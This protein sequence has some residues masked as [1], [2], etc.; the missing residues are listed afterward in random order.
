M[1]D[2]TADY[3][4]KLEAVYVGFEYDFSKIETIEYSKKLPVICKKH[5][6]FYQRK[7]HLLN[8]YGCKKCSNERK[9]RETL[10][11]VENFVK[12]AIKAHG[13]KYDYSKAVYKGANKKLQIICPV[14]GF[15]WQT[16]S[17]HTNR[18]SG[19][20][21]CGKM[22]AIESKLAPYRR[23]FIKH[24]DLYDYSKVE[25]VG[26]HTK[27]E[28]VCPVHG[29]FWQTPDAHKRGQGC[30]RCSSIVSKNEEELG[31]FIKSI[32]YNDKNVITN[33]RNI[34]GPME[35]DI[36]IPHK[37]I[38]IEFDGLYWHSTARIKERN[39]HLRKTEACE[40]VGYR[41]IHIY[42]DEWEYKKERV[43]SFLS[44]VLHANNMKNE[45]ARLL[46][47][48]DVS[49]VE[50]RMFLDEHHIQGYSGSSI[51]IGLVNKDGVLISY[52]GFKNKKNG[53]FELNRFA[54]RGNVR[55]GFSKLLAHFK[56]TYDWETIVSYADRRHSQGG[57]Y[58]KNGFDE[59]HETKPSF[60]YTR[61]TVR[62][63]RQQ[64]MKKYLPSKFSDTYDPSLTEWENMELQGYYQIWNCGYTKYETHNYNPK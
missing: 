6:L 52:M 7:D 17:S 35:L 16:P 3:I 57:V 21:E 39:Y 46:Y 1:D 13:Y 19:C 2:K 9:S 41:L 43:K 33:D 23:S 27:I 56:R 24:P 58:R 61:G 31:Q 26:A 10:S 25:Y 42:E 50:A 51:K 55:G 48:V 64:F 38:A 63:N 30:P 45:S 60:D 11:S 18:K 37:K 47:V 40:S 62:Y 14:H 22:D 53:V 29:S 59:V 54:T 5:G 44:N 4:K 49:T 8:G 34:I 12:N 28:I 15:F 32:L 20:P 36:V